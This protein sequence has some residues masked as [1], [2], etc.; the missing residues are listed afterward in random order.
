MGVTTCT[1]EFIR[2]CF[3]SSDM[4]DAVTKPENM[5]AHTKIFW[6]DLFI[7][8]MFMWDPGW[9]G[10]LLGVISVILLGSFL[11]L[12]QVEHSFVVSAAA[13]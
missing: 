12:I 5:S 11:K 7:T 10:R 13:L 8:S 1:I 6:F 2:V 4:M 3:D 9:R